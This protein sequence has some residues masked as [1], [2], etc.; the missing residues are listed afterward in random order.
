MLIFEGECFLETTHIIQILIFIL[1]L[2]LSA[3]FSSSET[4]LTSVNK[5][6]IK[7]LADS[8]DKRAQIV[9]KL[10]ENPTKLLSTILVGNNLVNIL[11][12]SIATALSIKFWGN[13]GVGIATGAVTFLVLIFGEITPKSIAVDDAEKQALKCAPSLNF[14]CKLF[15]PL[16][17]LL[18][19][20]TGLIF[21]IFKTSDKNPKPFVTQE[22]FLAMVNMGHEEGV[23]EEEEKEMLENVFEFKESQVKNVM[24]PRTEIITVESDI[25]YEELKEIFRKDFYSRIPVC[26]DGIDKVIG[27]LHVRDFAALDADDPRLTKQNFDVKEFMHKPYFTYE[28]QSVVKLLHVMRSEHIHMAIVLDEYGG[29]AGLVTIEDLIE[30]IIGDIEDEFDRPDAEI[31]EINESEYYIEGST[32]IEDVN[33]YFDVE[34]PEDE[35]DS[36]G[37]FLYREFDRV[38]QEKES[39]QYQNLL[40][41]IQKM[42]K[43]RIDTIHLKIL[44]EQTEDT[45]KE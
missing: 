30:E 33:D 24:T 38:P 20:I 18:M 22:E 31:T 16:T 26:E 36:I 37:G 40:F 14:F 10:N 1:C 9:M 21:K 25:S 44:P 42:D 35:F 19:K 45:E 3:Y 27:F 4:A 29:T 28:L 12:S 23:F 13:T 6:R 11:A 2:I 7:N 32:K 5:I 43:N 8:G 17:F 15:T 39:I 41:T 34:I